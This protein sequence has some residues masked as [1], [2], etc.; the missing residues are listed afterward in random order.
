MKNAL[1]VTLLA[2]A[3]SGCAITERKNQG[4]LDTSLVQGNTLEAITLAKEKAGLDEKTN[5][6]SDQL[7]GMQAG[8]LLRMNKDYTESNRYFDSIEDVMF[9]ED[10]EGVLESTGELIGSTITNDAMLDYEQT[11]YDSVMVNTYKALNFISIGDRDSARIE[12]NRSDERQRRAAD[13]FAKKINKQKEQLEGK[14]EATSKSLNKSLLESEKVVAQHNFTNAEWQAY[15]GYINPF[16]TFMHGLFFMLNAQDNSDLNKAIDSLNRVAAITQTKVSADT[17]K[18]AEELQKG[19]SNLA[20][21][22]KVWVVFEN[23]RAV[24]KE[25]LRID[26]PLFLVSDNVAYTGIALPRLKEL[27]APYDSLKV[28]DVKT[29]VVGDMDKIIQA[30][31]KEEF[32]V[33]LTKEISRTLIKTVA[34][35]QINDQNP[36]LGLGAGLLQAISTQ[37]D[38]RT[39]SMLPKNFQAAVVDAPAQGKLTL[40][41]GEKTTPI[42]VD[43]PAGKNAIV[44]VKATTA[45]ALPIVDVISL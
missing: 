3:I 38:T 4:K 1:T 13:Y 11:Y 19:T 27:P 34:Q 10:T 7:W 17:L 30:E 36:L 37:A 12:W 6:L 42:D 23:G 2:L 18:L 40:S 31:F 8:S 28:G 9:M 25:E 15:D 41:L 29:E 14:D 32:P 39:W 45:T 44:Y 35:K 24:K 20:G 26:L 33:I 21:L 43:I 5:Q 16:S 22:N